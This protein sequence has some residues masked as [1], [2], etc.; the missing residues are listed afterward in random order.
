MIFPTVPTRSQPCSPG[1][2][3]PCP[4]AGR[5][6][7]VASRVATQ[8]RRLDTARRLQVLICLSSLACL[9]GA[10]GQ[11]APAYK[12]PRNEPLEKYDKPPA[13]PRKKGTSPPMVP[14]F[15]VFIRQPV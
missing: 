2:V 5:T 8:H 3:P 6:R 12:A 15:G 7:P 9:A 11:L 1:A 13:P 14:Q 10:S 4:P